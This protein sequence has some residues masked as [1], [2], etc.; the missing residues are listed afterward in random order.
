MCSREGRRVEGERRGT[1]KGVVGERGK[2][3]RRR[4]GEEL[5]KVY[6]VV[7][8][9]RIRKKGGEGRGSTISIV[10]EGRGGEREGE[11][12]KVYLFILIA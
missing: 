8:E 6:L 9:R 7:E 3:R 11:L 12:L 10:G 2:E 4:R 5:P 1:T